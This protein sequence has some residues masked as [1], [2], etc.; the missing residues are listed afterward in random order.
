MLGQTAVMDGT[1]IMLEP[2]AMLCTGIALAIGIMLPDG[3]VLPTGDMLESAIG[4]HA[5]GDVIGEAAGIADAMGDAS[6]P[7]ATPLIPSD[8]PNAKTAAILAVVP[9][10]DMSSPP[11]TGPAGHMPEGW[12]NGGPDCQPS[13]PPRDPVT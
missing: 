6:W 7:I 4:G 9:L 12:L 13:A 11:E 8:S 10:C 2:G 3:M 1:G 5:A